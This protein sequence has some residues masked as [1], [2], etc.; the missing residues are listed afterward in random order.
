MISLSLLTTNWAKN[1]YNT[2][3][4]ATHLLHFDYKLNQNSPNRRAKPYDN[5]TSIDCYLDSKFTCE[6]FR[7]CIIHYTAHQHTDCEV[8]HR[9]TD[10]NKPL[11]HMAGFKGNCMAKADARKT[12]YLT[13]KEPQILKI[14]CFP[15]HVFCRITIIEEKAMT[16]RVGQAN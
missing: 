2:R 1:Y 15:I 11:I 14:A 10:S 9:K 7:S 5:A 13:E 6:F 12:D 4:E 3:L 8:V 16:M